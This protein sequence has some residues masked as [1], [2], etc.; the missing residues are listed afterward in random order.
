MI[1]SHLAHL[2]TKK[3]RRCCASKRETGITHFIF[4]VLFFCRLGYGVSGMTILECRAPTRFLYTLGTF[5]ASFSICTYVW[6][7]DRHTDLWLP[8]D[9]HQRNGNTL[10]EEV[11]VCLVNY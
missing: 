5:N 6:P 10:V 2:D 11:T 1:P 8:V 3:H 7:M 9:R 4:L